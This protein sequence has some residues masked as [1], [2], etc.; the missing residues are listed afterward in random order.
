MKTNSTRKTPR[1]I[2]L[3]KTKF[4]D[5]DGILKVTRSKKKLTSKG[6]PIRCITDLANKTEQ[7]RR[8]WWDIVQ[9]LT[10]I[11]SSPKIFFLA[12]L[13]LRFEGTITKLQ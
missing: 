11:N 7:G 8:V 3:K 10:E 13:S 4:K 2:L 12:K 6:N 9:K 1:Q 5:R